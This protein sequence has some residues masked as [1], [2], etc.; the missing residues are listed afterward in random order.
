MRGDRFRRGIKILLKS[1]FN[2]ILMLGVGCMKSKNVV[3]LVP[4]AIYISNSTIT[5]AFAKPTSWV[6]IQQFE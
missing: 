3:S 2:I 1:C 5:Q 6:K 4:I